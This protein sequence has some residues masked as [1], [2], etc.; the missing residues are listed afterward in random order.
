MRPG[1]EAD[2]GPR[3][4]VRRWLR[5]DETKPVRVGMLWKLIAAVAMLLAASAALAWLSGHLQR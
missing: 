1:P 4:F 5:F 2:D 3:R